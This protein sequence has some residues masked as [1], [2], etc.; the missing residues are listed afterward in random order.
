MSSDSE[1]AYRKFDAARLRF[2]RFAY[3]MWDGLG[4]NR[5]KKHH[6]RVMYRWLA[7][8]YIYSHK[9]RTQPHESR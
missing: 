4:E 5:R 9:Q 7:K 6:E 3:G 1:R 8:H 2:R